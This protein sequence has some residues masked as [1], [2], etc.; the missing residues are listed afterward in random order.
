MEDNKITREVYK[1]YADKI[2]SVLDKEGFYEQFKN[3]VEKGSS[4]FK[5]AKKRLIQDIS[6]DWIDTIESI[7]PNL[8]TIVR[9]PRKFIVQEEDIVDVSLARS[10][11]T[12]SVKYLA[13]HTNMISKV[14]EKTGDV[15]PSKILNITKEES[16][17]IYENR[18]IYTLLLKLKDFVTMR[19]DKIKKA[20]A[21][22]DVLELDIESRFNLPSKKITYRTEYFA[23]L[24]FDEVMRLDPDTL[25]KIERVAKIDRII[26]DF[27]SSSFAK[28]M[29]NSAPV[30]PPIMRTNVI[31]K[32]PNFKK[33][34]TLWQFVETYQA[35]AGFSTSDEVEEYDIED[36]SAK[37]LRSMITLNTMVFESL[38]D[39]CETDF[40]ME[41]KEFADFMRVGQMDFQKD[42][43]DRDEYAQK[44]DNK[45]E[46]GDEQ[47]NIEEVKPQ[48]DEEAEKE[49]P[50]E[51]EP[52][53]Q[54][55][56]EQEQQ[57]PEIEQQ[58]VE[59]EVEKPQ[60]IEKEVVVERPVE[61]ERFKE[62]PPKADQEEVDLEPDAEK[63]D[64]HLF[65]VRK[66]F[67]RPD[68]DKIKQEEIIKV[69]DA[70]DRCLT[71]YR[72]IKQE[73]LEE[74]D[75]QERIRRRREDIEKRAAAFKKQ[76]EELEQNSSNIDD[77][78]LG[79]DPFSYQ[80]AKI[81]R[82]KSEE[83]AKKRKEA[84]K[85]AIKVNKN[86][87]LELEDKN[88]EPINKAI[89]EMEKARAKKAERDA[90]IDEHLDN[91]DAIMPLENDV[92]LVSRVRKKRDYS[93][94]KQ[95]AQIAEQNAQ[96][97]RNDEQIDAQNG[98]ENGENTSKNNDKKPKIRI[99]KDNQVNP[100]G[101]DG[102]KKRR[103]NLT[104]VDEN[105]VAVGEVHVKDDDRPV[106][107]GGNA[108]LGKLDAPQ[109]E[110][111]AKRKYTRKQKSAEQEP[112]EE[113]ANIATENGEKNDIKI[114]EK[115][116]ENDTKNSEKSLENGVKI[117]ENTLEN[118]SKSEE[119]TADNDDA[120]KGNADTE[121]SAVKEVP[122]KKKEKKEKKD[123]WALSATT[124]NQKYTLPSGKDRVFDAIDESKVAVGGIRF[125][126][127][128]G[129][130]DPFGNIDVRSV[131]E[132]RRAEDEQEERNE[133]NDASSADK[134]KDN[135]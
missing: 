47:E 51:S 101:E 1:A 117:D 42:E 109:T 84:Q 76:R 113:N 55:P 82:E 79:M 4:V 14:D 74:R 56:Q 98:V 58:E 5:L 27:L 107:W 93:I 77:S 133:Q 127:G 2:V 89:D 72:R 44:L 8:D 86:E 59:K 71:S 20:S 94:A 16:F 18:F 132:A 40:D 92:P 50:P 63:F 39:Q 122:K 9:N 87:N 103:I 111:K 13:Q 57:E 131:A 75:R 41:D 33:A 95:T 60:E 17:E 106:L 34:L 68:D 130:T 97:A 61:V 90:K 83:E 31:L 121:N 123:P 54:E 134:D 29:R 46:N 73:E 128:S 116:L 64:Q 124:L 65:E 37:R 135:R 36:D 85:D 24:S 96:N 45:E 80:K 81:A 7:L 102:V 114:D 26:T 11:S 19:Y 25:T 3:R 30:R 129:I 100:W 15:T 125:K 118:M 35:T 69:K 49:V 99:A 53:E 43:I 38:Y 104:P 23:Q 6:I 88:T 91:I 12:E 52:Q 105:K 10:I 62:M 22:Q 67:K 78:A 115:S 32:E 21:T 28:S 119:K 126:S 120:H 112:V 110:Q 108:E 48:E 66:I 70:I